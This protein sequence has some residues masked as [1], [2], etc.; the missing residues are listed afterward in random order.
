M[1]AYLDIETSYHREITVVGIYRKDKG[2]SQLIGKDVTA[3][4]ILTALE[5]IDVIFTYNGERFDLPVIARQT[6]V[7]LLNRFK[8][9]DLMYDCWKMKLFGGLKKVEKTLGINRN[10][11]EVDGKLA[12]VLWDR[13]CWEND[14]DALDTL[15]KYNEEDVVNL[16]V[17]QN[18]LNNISC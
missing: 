13:Y 11:K 5:G 17:L 14:E 1:N 18:K 10:L 15:L 12:M 3:D 9:H 16:P 7:N 2:L 6:G 4:S 8:S